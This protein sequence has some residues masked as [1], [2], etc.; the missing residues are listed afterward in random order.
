MK[1]VILLAM[2]FWCLSVYADSGDA[3]AKTPKV[4]RPK[5]VAAPVAT[6]DSMGNVYRGMQQVTQQNAQENKEAREA[7]Q[8]A[9][10][11]KMQAAQAE[12]ADTK[13]Q[14][15]NERNDAQGQFQSGSVAAPFIPGGSTVSAAIGGLS[16]LKDSASGSNNSS[17]GSANGG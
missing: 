3:T 13:T 15:D 6:S 8:A 17:I 4:N 9:N 2:I 14:I 11:I 16:D 1:I 10:K 5:V 12:V 7:R